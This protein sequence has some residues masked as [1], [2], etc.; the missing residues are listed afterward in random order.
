MHPMDSRLRFLQSPC[1]R[2]PRDTQGSRAGMKVFASE[3]VGVGNPPC[4][5]SKV[6]RSRNSGEGTS[7]RGA[8]IVACPYRKPLQ[9][10]EERHPKA[11]EKRC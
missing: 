11:G 3:G 4:V 1:Y 5:R 10:D 9:V 7:R 2:E 6:M 8:A